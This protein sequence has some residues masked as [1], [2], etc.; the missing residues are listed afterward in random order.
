MG[1]V[2]TRPLIEAILSDWKGALGGDYRAYRGHVY[3]VFH[4]ACWLA[5]RDGPPPDEEA[6]A[7]A[8]AHHDLGIWSHHTMDYLDPSAE[9]ARQ[10]LEQTGRA[11][12]HGAVDHMIREHHKVRH[13]AGPCQLYTESF[14]RADLVD[15]SHGW[16][17][18]GIPRVRLK[19]L[20]LR[21]P[22]AG[23]DRCLARVITRW[24]VAHPLRPLPMFKL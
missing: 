23:F 5:G 24:V 9:L 14:R 16:I 13:Y 18:Y 8:A 2:D 22:R 20:T 11:D 3:R 10:F 21:F 4:V 17:R 6:V 19:E 15:L 12:K 1:S 7:I